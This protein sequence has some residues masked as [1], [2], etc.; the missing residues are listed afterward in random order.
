MIDDPTDTEASENSETI[1][2]E[3]QDFARASTKRYSKEY[4][5]I[6]QELA[7]EGGEQYG[8]KDRAIRGESRAEMKFNI[9]RR[10][11][12][13]VI[14]QFKLY[15]YGSIVSAKSNDSVDKAKLA[16]A[17]VRGIE[18][19]NNAVQIYGN[20]VDR[21]VKCGRGYVFVTTDY[22]DAETFQQRIKL[23]QILNPLMVIEDP[24]S[25]DPTGKDSTRRAF[26][27]YLSKHEATDTYGKD[28][29]NDNTVGDSLLN[30]TYWKEP[31]DSIAVVT[32]FELHRK[33]EAIYQDASGNIL[34]G[35]D[36]PKKTNGMKKRMV[37]TPSVTV[38]K[39]VGK[40]VVSTTELA[41]SCI[42]IITFAGER[43]DLMDGWR[44]IGLVN[45]LMDVQTVINYGA[46]HTVEKMAT[47]PKT[48]VFVDMKSIAPYK[49]IWQQSNKRR[50]PFNP[51]DSIG[52]DGEKYTPPFVQ[53][54]NPD[55]GN[56]LSVIQSYQGLM[57]AIDG[58]PADMGGGANETA[59]AVLTRAK[60]KETSNY[61]FLSNAAESVKQVC[62]VI[63]E[64]ALL[65]GDTEQEYT[66]V[67]S[68][69]IEVRKIDLSQ[70]AI[71]LG[72]LKFDID[73]GP[74]ISTQ[75]KEDLR[76]LIALG[77]MLGSDTAIAFAPDIVRNSDIGN[78]DDIAKKLDILANQK[79][80]T[81]A[82]G[83]ADPAA[84][85]AL[86]KAS[87]ATD[88]LNQQLQQAN[89]YI[90]QLQLELANGEAQM[91]Q[92]ILTTQMNN[93]NRIQIEAMKQQGAMN[94]TQLQ[95]QADAAADTQA[96]QLELEK[97]EANKPVITVVQGV[98]PNY[99][100]VGGMRNDLG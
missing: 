26:V 93:E 82:T 14:N 73:A 8:E 84:I 98:K 44:Y 33:R 24:H 74:L 72:K 37:T 68:E 45:P 13:D 10:K 61:Q 19:D 54:M 22:V 35:K 29:V 86:E 97:V 49:D 75:R 43:V 2:A 25:E 63:L 53:N 81:G 32:Y 96:A 94:K 20:A 34:K 87:Q 71:D 91:K 77:S 42:P 16:Q 99:N 27:E 52:P 92:A 79:L 55:I 76:S 23:Q 100:S 1:I 3:F 48:N 70:Q 50:L 66:F 31:D 78:A 56:E 62:R 28:V 5:A 69:G 9:V 6:R 88:A 46:S 47:A 30:E 64:M 38:H 60:S 59:E 4:K 15:P 36:V 85:A 17:L 12:N 21:Q 7:F 67:T 11:C 89:I 51:F 80:G 90:Q 41:L 65:V 83:R 40:K 95:I 58:V 18:T 57:S 39:I